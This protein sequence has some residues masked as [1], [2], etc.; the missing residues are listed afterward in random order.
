M[1]QAGDQSVLVT[2]SKPTSPEAGAEDETDDKG[3]QQ[4]LR[5]FVI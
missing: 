2:A 3:N 1:G 4:S 5:E